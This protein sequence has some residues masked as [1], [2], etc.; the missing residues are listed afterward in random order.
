MKLS[1]IAFPKVDEHF[2]DPQKNRETKQS[3]DVMRDKYPFLNIASVLTKPQEAKLKKSV[4]LSKLYSD[5][6]HIIETGVWAIQYW[7]ATDQYPALM[8]SSYA[9]SEMLDIKEP[10]KGSALHQSCEVACHIVEIAYT[11]KWSKIVIVSGSPHMCRFAWMMAQGLGIEV[12]GFVA[13]ERD[14]FKQEL[15]DFM[16]SQKVSNLKQLKS[17]PTLS[18]GS[19]VSEVDPEDDA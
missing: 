1:K 13:T 7:P 11:Q 16:I 14:R 2:C 9:L 6:P 12:D 17:S 18:Q 8:S 5:R 19:S 10:A 15:A 4:D 3:L